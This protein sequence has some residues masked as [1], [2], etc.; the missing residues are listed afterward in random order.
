M[1]IPYYKDQ[2]RSSKR[3]SSAGSEAPGDL[4]IGADP[5]NVNICNKHDILLEQALKIYLYM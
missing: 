3:C 5:E 2:H 4:C 1:K